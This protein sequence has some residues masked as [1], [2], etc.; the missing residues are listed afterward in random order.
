MIDISRIKLKRIYIDN[1]KCMSNFELRFDDLSL[2][3]GPNGSG[4]STVF[5]IAHN[6]CRFFCGDGRVLDFFPA[7][8]LTKWNTSAE[9]TFRLEAGEGDS[10]FSYALTLEHTREHTREHS[11]ARVKSEKLSLSGKPLFGFQE[12]GAQLY[13][14]DH[15]EGP[16]L[17]LDW[18]RSG[19]G[20]LLSANRPLDEFRNWA[21]RL[22]ILA[23][24]PRNM[25]AESDADSD[26]LDIG[27]RNF[28]SWYRHL[29]QEKP[30]GIEAVNKQLKSILPGFSG[31]RSKHVG[32]T[33]RELM[34]DFSALSGG[35]N[36]YRL[37]E[38]SDGQRS[39]IALYTGILCAEPGSVLLLDEPD[40]YVTLPEIQPLLAEMEDECGDELPQ[41]VLAS[42]HPEAIDFL[43]ERAI[44]LMREPES[45]TR[46][47]Y[48]N[49]IKNDTQLR[50][51]EL[52]AQGLAP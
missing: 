40:N 52:Y 41:I 1:Y 34:A 25:P 20:A 32:G 33:R 9:Q 17:S 7:E 49:E 21:Y 28:S 26:I 39:L 16:K 24:D 50:I 15:Q 30:D 47:K 31:L 3:L 11:K 43:S 6:L 42:H 4:K 22:R 8:T 27:G 10:L 35:K 38:L 5:E 23:L 14:E 19:L 12:G 13:R 36:S 48:A 18:T 44:W 37:G 46:V 45:F 2:L 29:L 51:S